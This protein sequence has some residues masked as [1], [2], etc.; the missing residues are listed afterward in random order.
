M[1]MGFPAF[2]SPPRGEV[3][4]F[5]P[6]VRPAA[7]SVTKAA[8]TAKMNR[9]PIPGPIDWST[10]QQTES[11]ETEI[12]GSKGEPQ[13]RSSCVGTLLFELDGRKE[14]KEKKEKRR[15]TDK[16]GPAKLLKTKV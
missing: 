7:T 16:Q 6:F 3:I 2:R 5:C 11:L 15:E 1:V 9:S 13:K 10:A 8:N 4:A 14:K 12:P